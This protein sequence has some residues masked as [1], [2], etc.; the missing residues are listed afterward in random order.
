MRN[1]FTVT[2]L[3]SREQSCLNWAAHGK[4]S[5]EISIILGITERTI[6]FHFQNAYAKL[7]ISKR[8]ELSAAL[9]RLGERPGA[10]S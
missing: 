6:N 5:W 8:S 10:A 2:H 3:T 1:G 9:T 7:G 4:T